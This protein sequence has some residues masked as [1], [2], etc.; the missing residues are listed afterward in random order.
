MQDSAALTL[1]HSANR[2]FGCDASALAHVEANLATSL[3][4]WLRRAL[5]HQ[6][7]CPDQK[8]DLEQEVTIRILLSFRKK[9][10]AGCAV[11]NVVGFA[12]RS[13]IHQI[14]D[15]QPD[16]RRTLAKR[17]LALSIQPDCGW[18]RI[19]L[20]GLRY[21]TLRSTA[22]RPPF[23]GDLKVTGDEFEFN[24]RGALSRA[25]NAILE[26]AQA[27]VEERQLLDSLLQSSASHP[28][29]QLPIDQVSERNLAVEETGFQ[30]AEASTM[31]AFW[32]AIMKLTPK[33]RAATLMAMDRE[34]L[35]ILT[36]QPN[37]EGWVLRAIESAIVEPAPDLDQ[38]PLTDDTIATLCGVTKN[39]IHVSRSRARPKT[40]T[41]P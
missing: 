31:Q 5:G 7:L 32:S 16:P 8:Q 30:Q 11:E 38:W 3:Q 10:E 29:Q 25:V 12:K 13:L 41:A 33:M 14:I 40:A 20:N 22:N 2:Y 34:M 15:L 9:R 21:L 35:C 1:Q 36:G 27:P 23:K 4:N 28:I 39:V 17:L 24:Q 26:Y 6:R 37:P 18:D 19:V